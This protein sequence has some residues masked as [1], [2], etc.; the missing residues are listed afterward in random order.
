MA[1]RV[2]DASALLAFMREETGADVVHAA[3][4]AECAISVVNVAEVLS[5]LTSDGD[6]PGGTFELIEAFRE[7]LALFA[8]EREDLI[9]I[10]R[11]RPLTRAAGLSLADRACLAL[12]HRLGIPALSADRQW[13][14]L[15]LPGIEV[16][17]IR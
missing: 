1:E 10:A 11:L 16:E 8:L 15:D 4:E 6:E 17:L 14:E 5:K 13:A 12:A 3:L 9:E 2:L 7:R